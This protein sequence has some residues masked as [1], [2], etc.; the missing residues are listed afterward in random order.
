[1]PR[2]Q[3]QSNP[4]SRIPADPAALGPMR[5]GGGPLYMHVYRRL[6]QMIENG[7]L[8]EGARLPPSR[9]LARQLDVS[10]CTVSYA[11]DLLAADGYTMAQGRA[12]TFVR[13]A[14]A[15]GTR[16]TAQKLEATPARPSS[17]ALP[18]LAVGMPPIDQFPRKVWVNLVKRRLAGLGVADLL[19]PDPQGHPLLRRALANRLAITR[20][21]TCHPDQV[22]VTSGIAGATALAAAAL[23]GRGDPVLVEDPLD[24]RCFEALRAAGARLQ[25]VAVDESGMDVGSA[26]S[27]CSRPALAVVT[28]CCQFPMGVVL[29]AERRALLLDAIG[30]CQG[31]VLEHDIQADYRFA[32][33]STRSLAS[34]NGL[35]CVIYALHL[36]ELVFPA[37]GVSCVAV[38][39]HLVDRFRAAC[40][41]LP[42]HASPAEQAALVDLVRRGHIL[43]YFSAAFEASVRRRG[44]L[45]QAFSD[46]GKRVYVPDAGL[47]VVAALDRP[48][49]APAQESLR[50]HGIAALPLERYSLSGR[51]APALLAGFATLPEERA[52]GVVRALSQLVSLSSGR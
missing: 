46:L 10:R 45:V 29:S 33:P 39:M 43:R 26:L 6:A 37:L 40:E 4:R 18:L 28:P 3:N 42:F 36:S 24:P 35:R 14:L 23:V 9:F 52:R 32:G 19:P 47:H 51:C 49:D 41:R 48:L 38:P 27:R 22:F 25:A 21:I 44:A 15:R 7:S 8:V 5:K 50:E 11:Y 30:A 34:E 16:G 31:H 13:R 17:H 2:K 12:G 1:M 20:G